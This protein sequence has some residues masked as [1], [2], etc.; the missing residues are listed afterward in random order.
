L[1]KKEV[2]YLWA[3]VIELK[4]VGEPDLKKQVQDRLRE[5][6][7]HDYRCQYEQAIASYDDALRMDPECA[8]AWFDKAITLNKMKKHT[9]ATICVARAV[10]LYRRIR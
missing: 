3:G 2:T 6:D 8:E 1:V 7:M 9:E 5:G 10:D 4:G